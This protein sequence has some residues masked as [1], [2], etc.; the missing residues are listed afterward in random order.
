LESQQKVLILEKQDE[1]EG[2]LQSTVNN[3]FVISKQS[4]MIT[5]GFEC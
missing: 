1:P 5:G 2:T 4:A 3:L